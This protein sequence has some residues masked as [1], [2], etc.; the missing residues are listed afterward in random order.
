MEHSLSP[1]PRLIC[2]AQRGA[3]WKERREDG[4]QT[5]I[6]ENDYCLFCLADFPW[7]EHKI[8]KL[9]ITLDLTSW[10]KRARFLPLT[11]FSP[12]GIPRWVALKEVSPVIIS[13]SWYTDYTTGYIRVHPL[14]NKSQL[15]LVQKHPGHAVPG[16]QWCI[17]ERGATG[18]DWWGSRSNSSQLLLLLNTSSTFLFPNKQCLWRYLWR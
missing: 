18:C 7:S 9:K 14:S 10:S 5:A 16:L 1:P 12:N 13:K 11:S 15:L 4:F 6:T 17:S 2:F 8:C 3:E